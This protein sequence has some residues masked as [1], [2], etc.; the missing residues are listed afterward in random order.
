MEIS[1]N[2]QKAIKKL[3]GKMRQ[4]LTLVPRTNS[5]NFVAQIN[6]RME[7]YKFCIY[8]KVAKRYLSI[9]S[10]IRG[11][12]CHNSQLKCDALFNLFIDFKK[13]QT[14]LQPKPT[15]TIS[16]WGGVVNCPGGGTVFVEKHAK[17][18]RSKSKLGN[19]Y[20]LLIMRQ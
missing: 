14:F 19:K 4:T 8:G 12:D 6:W 1:I 16:N 3:L 2:I 15:H 9:L 5:K 17:E 13:S 20:M 18:N 11:I 7:V 10:S